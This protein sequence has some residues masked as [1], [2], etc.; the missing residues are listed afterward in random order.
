[1]ISTPTAVG[2]SQ[3]T[4]YVHN[5]LRNAQCDPPYSA[6]V[7]D[8]PYVQLYVDFGQYEPVMYEIQL[9]DHCGDNGE[10]LF[11]SNY[12]VGQTPEGNWFG[13]FKYFQPVAV[14]TFVIWLSAFVDVPGG[15]VEKTFFSEMF[16]VEP[17]DHLTKV[18][19][20]QPAGALAT[21]FDVNGIYYGDPVPG[22]VLGFDGVRYF[23]I[24]W[25]RRGK[26]RELSNKAT[27]KSSLY[28]T[29]RST[30]ERTHQLEFELVPKW[31]KDV[32]L[33]IYMRG[34]I[35]VNDGPTMIVSDLNFEALNDDDL[36]WRAYPQLKTTTNL[37]FGCD[38][39]ECVE[40]CSPLVISAGVVTDQ[41]SESPAESVPDESIPPPPEDNIFIDNTSLDIIIDVF[42]MDDVPIPGSYATPGNTSSHYL[43]LGNSVNITVEWT[44]SISNQHIRLFD[45]NGVDVG[46]APVT[47]GDPTPQFTFPSVDMTG[48]LAMTLEV[49]NGPC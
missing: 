1:M 18:K 35:Q 47:A 6:P 7:L 31:Y 27:F 26:L 8:I 42:T 20:C 9:V 11:P 36:Q 32:L 37:Y 39:S 14:T 40:C 22:D 5:C 29:F 12:I 3:Y 46:C 49:G 44:S 33:A 15:L 4:N 10:Q 25:V 34:A 38:D 2:S 16:V 41:E 30:L 24:A 13:V 28:R 17:C 43:L 23:H 21:G 19:A 45:T 48:P